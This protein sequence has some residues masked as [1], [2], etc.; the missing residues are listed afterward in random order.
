MSYSCFFFQILAHANH[1]YFVLL[2]FAI[3]LSPSYLS[4]ITVTNP[5]CSKNVQSTFLIA[6]CN[7][8]GFSNKCYFDKELYERT[9]HGGHCIDCAE[10]RDG[11][12][13]ERC[14]E[15]FYQGYGDICLPCNCNPTGEWTRSSDGFPNWK[16]RKDDFFVAVEAL[17]CTLLVSR[18]K[19]VGWPKDTIHL[20]TLR[21]EMVQLKAIEGEFLP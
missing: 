4:L 7:C 18:P 6:A 12:N 5:L 21:T 3:V 10:N 14:K 15:N 8:N 2:L 11:P 16:W 17:I 9:G 13:C 19:A 20:I 1:H